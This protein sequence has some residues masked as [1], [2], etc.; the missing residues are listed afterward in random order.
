M[1][2]FRKAYKGSLVIEILVV[3]GINDKAEEFEKLNKVLQAIKPDRV[4]IS[5]IDRPPAYKVKLVG[6]DRLRE[7]SM[8]IKNLH[9]SIAYRK[10]YEGKKNSFNDNE[11]LNLISK[12]PQSEIDI[13]MSFDDDSKKRFEKLLSKKLVHIE[14]IAGSKFFVV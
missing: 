4:D 13:D 3:E 2:N 14:M 6:T 12:R 11:I 7:L 8:Y 10:D 9:V 5:T 1:I